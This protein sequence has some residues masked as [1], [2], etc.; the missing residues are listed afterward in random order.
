MDTE[1][2]YRYPRPL[3][4]A[5]ELLSALAVGVVALLLGRE[6]LRYLWSALGT[7]DAL[8]NRAPAL[9]DMV[10][11]IN[12]ATVVRVI[13]PIG[14]LPALLPALAWTAVALLL[15]LLLRNGLPTLR[16]SPRGMLVEFGGGWL[17]VPWESV[18]AI[19]VTE[20]GDRYV[21][22]A[23]TDS[24]QLT[25]WHRGY[26]LIYRLGFRPGFLI[27]SAIGD[28]DGL[29]KTLLSETDRVARV[30][31]NA[32]PAQLQEEAT[33]PLFRLLLSP[34]AFFAQRSGPV[35]APAETTAVASSGETVSGA[36]PGRISA[37]FQWSA[38]ILAVLA[39]LRYGVAWLS[40]L[41]LTF[42]SL[43]L[44]PVFDRLQLRALPAPW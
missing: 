42:P 44:L 32:R 21:L 25:G 22:L 17:A 23:E 31:D 9:R 3:T 7:D 5:V 18:K 4:W 8:F 38:A 41:A 35:P 10:V 36:Y 40:F 28:F 24:G 30:L 14:T 29:V 34:A 43:R 27:T 33:S 20:A 37:I 11:A 19:K 13:D 16:T 12:G 6:L 15:A 1:K 2:V 26:S 39:L